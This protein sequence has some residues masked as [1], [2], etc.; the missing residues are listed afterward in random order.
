MGEILEDYDCMINYHP[1]N[2]NVVAN[3]LSRQVQVA[4]LIIKEL[5]SLKE[6]TTPFE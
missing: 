6:V 4:K 2:A 3:A 5:H 1:G